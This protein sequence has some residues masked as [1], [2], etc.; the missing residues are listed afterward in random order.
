MAG[1]TRTGSAHRSAQ[2]RLL[3]RH[4]IATALAA[5]ILNSALWGLGRL[6]GVDFVVVPRGSAPADAQTISVGIIAATTIVPV[7]LGS[8]L[9]AATRGA[10]DRWWPRSALA[11]L[12]V[13]IVT[14]AMPLAATASVRDQGATAAMHLVTGVYESIQVRRAITAGGRDGRADAE[15]AFLSDPRLALGRI[16]TVDPK[17]MP[18]VVPTG[19]SWDVAAGELVLGGHDVPATR[20]ARHVRADLESP[21]SP[22]A[23]RHVPRVGAMG[24]H[25]S[26]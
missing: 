22:S 5:T 9:L 26:R 3:S 1:I 7:L 19:W 6:L 13:W 11:G 16:A 15:L 4:A 17:G 10:S 2:G 21:P 25:H 12:A 18:H 20:R 23:G 24:G 14:L 8:G